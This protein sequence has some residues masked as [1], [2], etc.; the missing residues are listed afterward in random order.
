MATSPKKSETGYRHDIGTPSSFVKRNEKKTNDSIEVLLYG[1][2]RYHIA[3]EEEY[4]KDGLRNKNNVIDIQSLRRLASKGIPD[5]GSHRGVVWR[6]LMNYLPCDRSQWKE[7]LQRQRKTYR[8][9]V[10]ELFQNDEKNYDVNNSSGNNGQSAEN[11]DDMR[12]SQ[13]TD[14]NPQSNQDAK[15]N[16]KQSSDFSHAKALQIEITNDSES[17]SDV[18]HIDSEKQLNYDDL[19]AL[20][21]STESFEIIDTKVSNTFTHENSEINE[22]F[23]N[24]LKRTFSDVPT[25]NPDSEKIN[26]L[27]ESSATCESTN[28]SSQTSDTKE[29]DEKCF[30]LENKKSLNDEQDTCEKHPSN[31][32]H[33]ECSTSLPSSSNTTFDKNDESRSDHFHENLALLD[34]IRKDV[35]RTHPSFHFFLE[36]ED[37]LGQR[38]Y[39]A[40]ERILFVWAKLNKGVRLKSIFKLVFNSG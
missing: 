1:E 12:E 2:N 19:G 18:I 13:S 23:Q 25:R 34:E 30:E 39:A 31:L 22:A 17:S 24:K 35:V 11:V 9:L 21:K 4:S 36:P 3:T 7:V 26:Y 38:R 10:E 14:E 33:D 6:I 8:D 40:I 5:N 15:E 37:N 20:K 32:N 27:H 28:I 16:V 29:G